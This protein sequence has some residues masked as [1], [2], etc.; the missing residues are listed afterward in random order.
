MNGDAYAAF[1][2]VDESGPVRVDGDFETGG[3]VGGVL[4]VGEVYDATSCDLSEKAVEGFLVTKA[5]Y[6]LVHGEGGDDE[7]IFYPTVSATYRSAP[8]N[9]R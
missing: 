9:F 8:T 4:G 3:R 2:A 6:S 5:W 1:A 7:D